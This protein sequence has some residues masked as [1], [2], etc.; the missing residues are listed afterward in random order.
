[1]VKLLDRTK[2]LLKEYWPY[3]LIGL[4][5]L[6]WFAKGKLVWGIDASFPLDLKSYTDQ[7][8]HI[9]NWKIPFTTPDSS[10][11][12][13][14]A[15]LVG[16]LYL[17]QVLH[18]PF[19][20]L[21]FQKALI[22]ILFVFSGVS[23]HYL[24]KEVFP[25]ANKSGSLI[26]GLF[27]MFSFYAFSCWH[28][29]SWI[30]FFHAFFPLLFGLF[31]KGIR[32]N[33]GIKFFISLALLWTLLVTP[34]YIT[35]PFV[36]TSFFV[37]FSYLIF[38]LSTHFN[39]GD[40][41]RSFLRSLAFLGSWFCFN[42]FWIAPQFF[43]FQSEF[44]RRS[45]PGDSWGLLEFNSSKMVDIFRFLGPK[46]L[47]DKYR[48]DLVYT[49]FHYYSTPLFVIIGFL[50]TV[51][52]FA[53]LLKRQEKII[54]YLVVMFLFFALLLFG[55]NIPFG[56]FIFVV[57]SKFKL[58]VI[59]RSI[60]Q[61]F[62]P[63]FVLFAGLLFA[64]SISDLLHWVEKQK[65]GLRWRKIAIF[66]VSI[67][68][69]V[70]YSF[71]F[72]TGKIFQPAD[73]LLSSE[74]IKIPDDYNQISQWLNNQ[75]GAHNFNILPLPFEKM[76]IAALS[77]NNGSDGYLG[78]Y[79]LT[80]TTDNRYIIT[81]TSDASISKIAN[82]IAE[83]GDVSSDLQKYNIK[84]IIFHRDTNWSYIKRNDWF[85]STDQGVIESGLTSGNNLKKVATFG[86]LDV[87]E[88]EGW[89]DNLLALGGGSGQPTIEYKKNSVVS[90]K[91][92]IFNLKSTTSLSYLDTYNPGWKLCGD[93]KNIILSCKNSLLP[94][95][96]TVPENGIGNM[97]SVDPSYIKNNFKAGSYT[98]NSDGSINLSLT[99]YF[100][101][102]IYLDASFVISL[103]GILFALGYIFYRPRNKK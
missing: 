76:G 8:F 43:F 29:L 35:P 42:I 48:G 64:Y 103:I 100:W 72:W 23:A 80:Y 20:A 67:V 19:S 86:K 40:I 2:L 27:Y 102:Q 85:V 96:Q 78:G 34:A 89:T 32:D 58:D 53:V 75:D 47:S 49:W 36:L 3:F 81:D 61:R 18:L 9:W 65:N 98:Q 22:Y 66:S 97:W 52:I 88:N 79:P 71:P 50:I 31:I 4:V 99:M 6:T 62:M 69:F 77:W 83:Q 84:Y 28:A 54:N 17:V 11:F 92:N 73:G 46:F 51:I 95:D 41:R 90:Y 13:L 16:L 15:P 45:V 68:F 94:R 37:L 44:V 33:K 93:N 14:V 21:L 7:Y 74:K 101:P 25:R 59:F 26:A 63:F 30:I 82:Q 1:M 87:Y 38:H 39:K 60:W 70:V 5:S 12:P 55:T 91:I 57:I 10:K 24:F 56:K